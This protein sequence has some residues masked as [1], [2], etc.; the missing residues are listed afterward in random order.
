MGYRKEEM[1][2]IGNGIS[3]IRYG[4]GILE[5]ECLISEV[6]NQISG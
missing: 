6:R 4:N 3:D 1:G 2:L 5:K